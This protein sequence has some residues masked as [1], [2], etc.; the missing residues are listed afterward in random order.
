M[1]FQAWDGCK[2]RN[3][4]SSNTNELGGWEALFLASF[5]HCLKR[6]K[7]NV[8]VRLN[9][10]AAVNDWRGH[11]SVVTIFDDFPGQPSTRALGRK[12]THEIQLNCDL[13]GNCGWLSSVTA[14][15]V[16]IFLPEIRSGH[17]VSSGKFSKTSR[18]SYGTIFF[19]LR[20]RW[21]YGSLVKRIG[22]TNT[23]I[24]KK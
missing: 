23:P 22:R 8:G 21:F 2:H 18:R 15:F 20:H 5:F 24:V 7:E 16:F 19:C 11:L 10:M 4:N 1:S 17:I 3:N 6:E 14:S 13:L 12:K 9:R